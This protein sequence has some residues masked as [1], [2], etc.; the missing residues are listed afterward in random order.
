MRRRIFD[1]LVGIA[2]LFLA[3]ADCGAGPCGIDCAPSSL[4]RQHPRG[5][6]G[7]WAI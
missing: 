6:P 7:F 3:A 2:G 5:S 1:M 4:I